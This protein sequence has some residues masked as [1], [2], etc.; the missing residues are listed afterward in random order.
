MAHL[1]IAADRILEDE[2]TQTLVFRKIA[3]PVQ[4]FSQSYALQ[5]A[6][7]FLAENAKPK[8]IRLTLVPDEKPATYTRFG[9][10]HCNPYGFWRAQWDQ[11]SAVTFPIA[12]LMSI[13]GN[14]ILRYRNE[15]GVVSILVLQGS[16]PRELRVG[17]YQG[18]IIHVAMQGRIDSPLPH[19]YVVGSGTISSKDGAYYARALA[20]RLGVSEA[21]IEFRAD[22]W[23]INEIWTPFFP[24]FDTSDSAPKRRHSRKPRRHTVSTSR[25]QTTGAR[26][27]VWS[28]FRSRIAASH[29]QSK[30]GY[31]S[32][33]KCFAA[34]SANAGGRI[35]LGPPAFDACACP[36][37]S[38]ISRFEFT[39]A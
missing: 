33:T 20:A 26:G 23:F 19:L 17:G 38:T 37:P 16:D 12:E 34:Q 24:L 25:Q 6:R 9:C 27:K 22:P 10:D 4:T 5:Q 21:W 18:K 31:P 3:V 7:Q 15:S 36:V 11:I 29:T 32:P 28:L 14:A 13:E 2:T 30:N 39:A 1:T 8:M 35:A